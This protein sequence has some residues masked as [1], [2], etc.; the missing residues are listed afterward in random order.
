MTRVRSVNASETEAR[1]G[2]RPSPSAA[3]ATCASTCLT[4]SISASMATRSRTSAPPTS[5]TCF[6]VSPKSLR[7]IDVFAVNAARTLPHGSFAWPCCST[8][9]TASRVIPLSVN[10]PTM[11][12]SPSVRDWTRFP[13]KPSSGYCATSKKSG[14]FRCPSRSATPVSMLDASIVTTTVAFEKSPS[15]TWMV[16]D[17]RANDPRTFA[18]TR[19]LTEKCKL[20][21]LLSISQRSVAIAP[22][23][24][25]AHPLDA[26]QE[27]TGEPSQSSCVFNH[28]ESASWFWLVKGYRNDR[29]HSH[30]EM[31]SR[32]SHARRRSGYSRTAAFR[33]RGWAHHLRWR[34]RA[35]ARCRR[36]RAP[37]EGAHRDARRDSRAGRAH[38]VRLR[39]RMARRRNASQGVP[40]GQRGRLARRGSAPAYDTRSRARR[41]DTCLAP[42]RR[43][44][45]GRHLAR[46]VRGGAASAASRTGGRAGLLDPGGLRQWLHV[47]CLWQRG[48]RH[49][50]SLSG[51]RRCGLSGGRPREGGVGDGSREAFAVLSE[52]LPRLGAHTAD[53]HPQEARTTAP[54]PS[55]ATRRL[56]KAF[57][58]AQLQSGEG[59]DS[60]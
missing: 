37:Q 41:G 38:Q 32:R 15:G 58:P 7:S 56:A 36:A 3:Q 14:D 42:P 40:V 49:R 25:Q 45:R 54:I 12:I 51:Q 8:R 46:F 35:P 4:A 17:Q 43:P 16:P 5:S 19:C 59:G 6:L 34:T 33:S 53:R 20:E 2:L 52:G 9:R 24:L 50:R 57:R 48:H 23:N 28:L 31:L 29:L 27:A 1:A 60:A 39:T 44:R 10:S 26:T 11:S 22:P 30:F 18:I 55:H 21:W 47:M 13:T